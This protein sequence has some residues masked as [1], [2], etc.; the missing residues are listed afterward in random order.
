MDAKTVLRMA[1]INGAKAI[2]M[3]D[4]IESIE[5]GKKADLAILNLNDIN[6]LLSTLIQSQELFI[7]RQEL[8]LKPRSLKGKIVMEDRIFKTLEKEIVLKEANNSTKR[9]IRRIPSLS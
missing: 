6:I 9:L 7:L 8:T 1:I 2:G 5:V 4:K 3:D